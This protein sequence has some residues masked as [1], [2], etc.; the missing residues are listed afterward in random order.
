M[1]TYN[2]SPND[3]VEWP[4]AEPHDYGTLPGSI[5]GSAS[6]PALV[7]VVIV[8]KRPPLHSLFFQC[9]FLVVLIS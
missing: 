4:Q 8:G 1:E 3:I 2:V 6:L 5:P 7:S 9:D